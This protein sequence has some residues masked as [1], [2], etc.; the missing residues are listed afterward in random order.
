MDELAHIPAG[1]GYVK[2]LDY[3]LNP[4]HPPLV[5]MIAALPLVFIHLNFPTD[6]AAWKN[7]INGRKDPGTPL[8]YAG[9]LIV[10]AGVVSM[11]IFRKGNQPE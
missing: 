11:F 5:K 3:R 4:E 1:Y 6:K 7:D 2:F 10:I 9:F 8:V